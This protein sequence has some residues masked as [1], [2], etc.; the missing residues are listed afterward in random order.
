MDDVTGIDISDLRR[1]AEIIDS[2]S[3][4]PIPERVNPLSPTET[5]RMLHELHVHEIELEIQNEELR[6]T[7]LE[8][9]TSRSKYFDLYDL[10]P[11]GYCTIND[12]GLIV[13]AN[14]TAT[15]LFGIPRS[16]LVHQPIKRFIAKSDQD[17]Y[18]L[19]NKRLL[20]TGSPQRYD[21][22]IVK[23][24]LTQLWVRIDTVIAD[25]N[26]G[27]P[28]AVNMALSDITESKSL[29]RAIQESEERYRTLVEGSPEPV[30]VKRDGIIL[31][32]NPSAIE[33][34]GA[35]DAQ[36]LEGRLF[37]DLVHQDHHQ[38]V[39][40]QESGIFLTNHCAQI[41]HEI[42]LK[43]DGTPID[44]ESK[45]TL[46]KYDGEPAIHSSLRDITERMRLNSALVEKNLE[47]GRAK[48]IA[49][50]ANNAKSDFISGMSHDLRTPLNAIL[51]FA[52]LIDTG[53]Q[54]L[55]PSQKRSID[56]IL[57]AGW[58]LLDL[59]NEI[60]DLSLIESGTLSLSLTPVPLL[61]VIK[62]CECMVEQQAEKH[63]IKLSVVPPDDP[64][65]ALADSMRLRQI[66]NNLL[67]NGIKYNKPGGTVIID[68]A[69][70]ESGFVRI[71]VRDT[72][73]GLSP[74][75]ITELFQPFHRLNKNAKVEQGTGIGLV[76]CKRLVESM[77][78]M[79]GVESV[80]GTG[81][82]FWFELRLADD[83]RVAAM[84]AEDS[85]LVETSKRTGEILHTILYIENT[86]S[87]VLSMCGLIALRSDMRL[88]SARN[89]ESG[90]EIAREYLPEVI[91]TDINLPGISALEVKRLLSE[92]PKTAHIPII[93][94]CDA[95]I[96][97]DIE[98]TLEK[99]RMKYLM[100]PLKAAEFLDTLDTIFAAQT[101]I[102]ERPNEEEN[103]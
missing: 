55:T 67:S 89:G 28:A 100:K 47:L 40:T 21:L 99:G 61:E 91:F 78:G 33:L 52:Q 4:H 53:S 14:L 101:N 97:D 23:S 66:L 69:P 32:V 103:I 72:G 83:D 70:C 50:K 77:G 90:L 35:S 84:A 48:L 54:P 25:N 95:T 98:K 74:G 15:S 73:E 86:P 94:L 75:Q 56:Q 46:I 57:K 51:G 37:L 11:V 26:N 49:E 82:V 43:T 27:A 102:N 39:L 41:V 1:Q 12:Q 10:A 42:L 92:S 3:K 18:Y 96:P 34:L 59:I 68:W 19:H 20:K 5:S 17:T 38:A 36:E 44:V 63:E 6:R 60:L 58:Y 7:Q 62:E 85:L 87:H 2:E 65:D 29:E 80:V 22:R 30:I 8:L 64:C 93:A 16:T 79:I 45:S 71:N 81:S 76:V 24:D 31:Y 13:Q 9:E 88:L